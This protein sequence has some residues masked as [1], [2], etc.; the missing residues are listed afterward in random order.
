MNTKLEM[1]CAYCLKELKKI[2]NNSNVSHGICKR[3]FIETLR[4]TGLP[5][6][7][8]QSL[9]NRHTYMCKDLSD[10]NINNKL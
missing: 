1:V 3:H 10:N 8:I 4:L 2:N 7:T 9:A 5:E 6:D